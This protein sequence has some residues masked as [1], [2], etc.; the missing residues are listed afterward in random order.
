MRSADHISKNI[1]TTLADTEINHVS[2]GECEGGTGLYSNEEGTAS[3]S[4]GTRT[5]TVISGH[6]AG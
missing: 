6:V 4:T 1:I 2:G 3:P 5:V